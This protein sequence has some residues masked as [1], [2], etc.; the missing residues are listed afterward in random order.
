MRANPTVNNDSSDNKYYF[1]SAFGTA[2]YIL[3]CINEGQSKKEIIY[4]LDDNEQLV[5]VWIEYLKGLHWL[6]EDGINGSLLP[7]QDS[8]SW[9]KNIMKVY[10]KNN[11]K[12]PK[13]LG[14]IQTIIIRN[15]KK[16]LSIH[17][18]QYRLHLRNLY[19]YNRKD[20]L[21]NYYYYWCSAT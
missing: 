15:H 20:F 7:S 21:W 3:K 8:K 12:P 10:K 4:N 19:Y 13:L 14:K 2:I 1:T 16:R 17:F 5:S 11:K 6:E 9:I 18:S